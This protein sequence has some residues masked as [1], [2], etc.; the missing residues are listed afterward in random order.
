M[1]TVNEPEAQIKDSDSSTAEGSLMPRAIVTFGRGWN[2]LA[3]VLFK[4]H[5]LSAE[6]LLSEGMQLPKESVPAG[7]GRAEQRAPRGGAGSHA[8]ARAAPRAP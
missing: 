6:I 1:V 4:R 3:V 5:R 2:A 8:R 7:F